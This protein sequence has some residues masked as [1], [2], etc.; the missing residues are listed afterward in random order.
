MTRQVFF[1]E[2]SHCLQNAFCIFYN[3]IVHFLSKCFQR[4][5]RDL[6]GDPYHKD[7]QFQQVSSLCKLIF[8]LYRNE[9]KQMAVWKLKF[10]P[11]SGT[12]AKIEG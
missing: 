7:G 9:R 5:C 3:N 4:D 1:N 2:F 12:T 11:D 6:R 10:W 8:I